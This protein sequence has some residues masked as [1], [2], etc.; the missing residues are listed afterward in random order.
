M[1]KYLELHGT[2]DSEALIRYAHALVTKYGEGS[3]EL[4]CQMYDAAAEASG[5]TLP[6]A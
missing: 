3:A 2:E 4:A 6:P 5:V 1:R